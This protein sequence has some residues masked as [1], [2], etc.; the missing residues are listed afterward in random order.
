[1]LA[2]SNER[3]YPPHPPPTFVLCSKN[4]EVDKIIA[5]S[6]EQ[7]IFMLAW[8][9]ERHYQEHHLCL[10]SSTEEHH[11]CLQ[12]STTEHHLFLQ[13][14][15]KV[16]TPQPPRTSLLLHMHHPP[17]NIGHGRKS[18]QAHGLLLDV[19]PKSRTSHNEPLIVSQ[20]YNRYALQVQPPGSFEKIGSKSLKKWEHTI[21]SIRL[22]L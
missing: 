17:N 8:N 11:L 14:T 15:T 6:I 1:M 10:Q 7:I 4:N 20:V 9:N 3:Q 21:L 2:W 13:A 5:I 18:A 22:S 19:P 12:S 16:N